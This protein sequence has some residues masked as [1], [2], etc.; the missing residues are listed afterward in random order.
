MVLV[1]SLN[2]VSLVTMVAAHILMS[3]YLKSNVPKPTDFGQF[4]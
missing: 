3:V 1:A 2:Y 4:Y